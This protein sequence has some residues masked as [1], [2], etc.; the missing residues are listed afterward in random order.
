MAPQLLI[1]KENKAVYSSKCDIWSIG[2]LL[3]EVKN[4][5]MIVVVWYSAMEFKESSYT[6]N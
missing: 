6:D 2:V 1:I 3:Y 4:F 5:S